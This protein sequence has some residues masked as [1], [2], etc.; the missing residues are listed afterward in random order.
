MNV[1]AGYLRDMLERI[2]RIEQVAADGEAIFYESFMHQDTIIRNYEV[3][4]EIVKR[5]PEEL[6]NGSPD[7]N[8]S[9]VKGFRDFLAHNYDRIEL[10]IVWGAV[11]QLSE[12]KTTVEA[13]LF[14]VEENEADPS[15]D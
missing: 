7:I 4:G 14:N 10:L 15:D 9:D 13:M 1:T 11:E 2:H 5:L 6:L 12:L 8:W 3:I